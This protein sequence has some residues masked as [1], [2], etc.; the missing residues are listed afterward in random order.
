[1]IKQ[2]FI[3][4]TSNNLDS[5][6]SNEPGKGNIGHRQR[7]CIW[8]FWANFGVIMIKQIFISKT[9]DNLDIRDSSQPG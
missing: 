1:M 6:D 2:I 8:K 9:S 5:R 7:N 4:K 3:S